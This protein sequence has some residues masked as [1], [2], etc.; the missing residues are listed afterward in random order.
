MNKVS[1]VGLSGSLTAGKTFKGK[2]FN[3]KNCKKEG[4]SIVG[5]SPNLELGVEASV[6][7]TLVERKLYA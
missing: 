5:N 3:F 1:S 6:I 7:L 4:N 2:F